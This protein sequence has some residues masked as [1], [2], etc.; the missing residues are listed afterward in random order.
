M[1][2]VLYEKHVRVVGLD[3]QRMALDFVGRYKAGE[4]I[5]SLARSSG[6]SYGAVHR[7]LTEAGVRLRPRG[8]S[9]NRKPRDAG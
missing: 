6:R 3:R 7:V 9:N 5:R 1:S 8:G 2:Q 4:S